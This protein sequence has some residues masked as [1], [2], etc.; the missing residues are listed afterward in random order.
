MMIL[1]TETEELQGN[2]DTCKDTNSALYK[3]LKEAVARN[4]EMLGVMKKNK[5]RIDELFGQI[6]L[7]KDAIMKIRLGL[8]ELL[9]H[10]STDELNQKIVESRD[11]LS[12]G[13]RLLEEYKKEGL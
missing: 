6:S 5:D 3:T 9:N 11:R 10:Q 8:P 13:Q 4:T 12:F 2:L 1:K 7:C